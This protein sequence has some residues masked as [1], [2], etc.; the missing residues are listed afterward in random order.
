MEYY[1]IKTE[2]ANHAKDL[3]TGLDADKWDSIDGFI[4]VGGD[5]LF[6]EVIVNRTGK[7]Q[8]LIRM[9]EQIYN[10]S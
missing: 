5:G 9:S 2:R 10:I 3:I 8:F 4:S 7:G 6:N 1:L